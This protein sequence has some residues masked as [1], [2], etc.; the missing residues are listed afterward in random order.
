MTDLSR[1]ELVALLGAAALGPHIRPRRRAPV[2][3]RGVGFRV[4]TITAGTTL[5]DPTDHAPV[6][7]ALAFLARA[8]QRFVDAGYEVQTVRVATQPLVAGLGARERAAAL[9]ALQALDRIVRVANAR[10]A[11][12]PVP[13]ADAAADPIEF[14]QWA[15]ELIHTTRNLSCSVAVASPDGGVASGAAGAAAQAMLAIARV[16]AGGI[17]NFNFAAAA[18][19]PAGTP[20]FPV[21]YHAGPEAFAIG[22]E[23][24]PLVAEACRA[25]HTLEEAKGRLASLFEARLGAIAELAAGLAEPARRRY[26]GIDA[27]PAPGKDASIGAAIEALTGLPFG[28][29]GT[30]AGCAAITDVLKRLR[31]RTCGY[32]GLML[33]VLEDPVLARRAAEGRYSVRELLLYSS[34]CGTGVDVIPLA[35]DVAVDRVAALIGDVAALAVKLA[36]PLSA[37]L[38]PVPGKAVGDVAHFDD[39]FLTDCVVLRLE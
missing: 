21:A 9:P 10:L 36:K 5:R 13:G 35:G 30:L 16:T 15:A 14:A 12:G 19:V 7:R 34:V 22:L 25:P 27:S 2:R 6:D 20:F 32:S 31:V 8:R 38:F 18:N 1:R 37:R 11:I 17:G 39:P 4:R 24:P 28:S 26:L 23:S 3:S 29:A 33:P